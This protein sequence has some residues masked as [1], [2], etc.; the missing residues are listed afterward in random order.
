MTMKNFDFSK[1]K[2]EDLEFKD[3]IDN[4]PDSAYIMPVK[5][6]ESGQITITDDQPTEEVTEVKEIPEDHEFQATL[7]DSMDK[8]DMEFAEDS[9]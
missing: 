3:D 6:G 2:P 8:I 4:Q 9:N 1:Y 7:Q 5:L